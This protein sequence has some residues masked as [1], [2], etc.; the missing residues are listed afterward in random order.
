MTYKKFAIVALTLDY[1]W[2][3]SPSQATCTVEY[4]ISGRL[5]SL[6][7]YYFTAQHGISKQWRDQYP[8]SCL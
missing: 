8:V 5:L 2:T 3:L 7:I 4:T 6:M 1:E